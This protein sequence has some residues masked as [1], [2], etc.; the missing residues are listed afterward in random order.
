[1]R[2]NLQ[3]SS[4]RQSGERGGVSPPVLTQID[5]RADAAPLAWLNRNKFGL[6][7][8]FEYRAD[9]MKIAADIHKAAFGRN[10]RGE[11]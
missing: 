4:M 10:Q 11:M 2:D 7:L 6:V 8:P 3:Q 9:V 5:W 1:M